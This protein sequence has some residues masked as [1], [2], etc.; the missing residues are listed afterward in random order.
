M[1]PFFSLMFYLSTFE[2]LILS[3]YALHSK[4]VIDMRKWNKTECRNDNY[5]ATYVFA[6][7][8]C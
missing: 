5:N 6:N 8:F 1:H 7:L 3:I 4:F 2:K